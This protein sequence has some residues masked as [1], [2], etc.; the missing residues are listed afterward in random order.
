M[1][2]GDRFDTVS[3]VFWLNVTVNVLGAKLNVHALP[4]VWLLLFIVTVWEDVLFAVAF[5]V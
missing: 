1:L 4:V 3:V 5:V 2:V